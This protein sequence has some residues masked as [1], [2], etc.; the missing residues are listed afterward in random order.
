MIL[1]ANYLNV[2]NNIQMI[3]ET[4]NNKYI[5]TIYY[6]IKN[7]HKKKRFDDIKQA[8]I[9]YFEI[10]KKLIKEIKRGIKK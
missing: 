6:M 2:Y 3:D 5:I 1:K 9:K 7:K 10:E 4:I 8:Y